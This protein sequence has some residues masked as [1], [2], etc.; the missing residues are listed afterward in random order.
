M[1]ISYVRFA[2]IACKATFARMASSSLGYNNANIVSS[3]SILLSS[4]RSYFVDDLFLVR[5]DLFILLNID[6]ESL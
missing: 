3:F 2:V 4:N 5:C 6:V 1:D